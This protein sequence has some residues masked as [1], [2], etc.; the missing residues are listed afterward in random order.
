MRS[1][2]HEAINYATGIKAKA[3]IL[4][5]DFVDTGQADGTIRTPDQNCQMSKCAM[6]PH[7]RSSVAP[8]GV[9]RFAGLPISL[10]LAF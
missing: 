2:G 5:A 9:A 4:L 10:R 3:M 6:L 7:G 8:G 1:L